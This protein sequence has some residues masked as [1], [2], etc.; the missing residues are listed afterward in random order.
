MEK[1]NELGESKEFINNEE[2]RL[3]WLEKD[4]KEWLVEESIDDSFIDETENSLMNIKNKILLFQGQYK[5]PEVW[6]SISTY[7]DQKLFSWFELSFKK[8]LL[9]ND[10]AFKSFEKYYLEKIYKQGEINAGLILEVDSKIGLVNENLEAITELIKNENRLKNENYLNIYENLYLNLENSKPKGRTKIDIFRNRLL[11]VR[12]SDEN[13]FFEDIY[14]KRKIDIDLFNNW[15]NGFNTIIGGK[16]LSGK[17]RAVYELLK[18]TTIE[19]INYFKAE[20]FPPSN[21]NSFFKIEKEVETILVF[22]NMEKILLWDNNKVEEFLKL[23]FSYTDNFIVGITN[24]ISEWE[25]I[26]YKYD[27]FSILKIPNLTEDVI[28]ELNKIEQINNELLDDTIGSYFYPISSRVSEYKNLSEYSKGVLRAYLEISKWRKNHLGEIMLL[29]QYV[30]DFEFIKDENLFKKAINEISSLKYWV[31]IYEENKYITLTDEV[32]KSITNE[33]LKNY[34][35]DNREFKISDFFKERDEIL[36][37]FQKETAFK[38]LNVY[39][40]PENH[41]KLIRFAKDDLKLE[42]MIRY[43]EQGFQIDSHMYVSML[44]LN[45]ETLFNLIDEKSIPIP[46]DDSHI[47]RAKCRFK[48]YLDSKITIFDFFE[49]KTP[50]LEDRIELLRYLAGKC[51]TINELQFISNFCKKIGSDDLKIGRKIIGIALRAQR[52]GKNL[53]KIDL[54]GVDIDGQFINSINETFLD[55]NSPKEK[56]AFSIFW[57]IIIFS[58]P[59]ENNRLVFNLIVKEILKLKEFELKGVFFTN[60]FKYLNNFETAI[61]FIEIVSDDKINSNNLNKLLD[62]SN[63]KE[64][65]D[66]VNDKYKELSLENDKDLYYYTQMLYKLR[67]FNRR[68]EAFEFYFEHKNTI[69]D[70]YLKSLKPIFRLGFFRAF[71][72]LNPKL[73]DLKLLIDLEYSIRGLIPSDFSTELFKNSKKNKNHD[74]IDL[75]FMLN[76]EFKYK[77][78][79]VN[80]LKN[81]IDNK[82]LLTNLIDLHPYIDLSNP[83]IL[84]FI[85]FQIKSYLIKK[86][87][88][89]EADFDNIIF[90]NNT[91]FKGTEVYISN[92]EQFLSVIRFHPDKY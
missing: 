20:A 47:I 29:W 53:Q 7:F 45:E 3:E 92:L 15:K 46:S 58:L 41:N 10:N 28:G 56:E 26:C 37:I 50:L 59:D 71:L 13:N 8:T 36:K 77:I 6:E 22:D 27:Q 63:K 30:Y 48:N 1:L 69:F 85:K 60:V 49:K 90:L 51:E 25:N 55:S 76:R 61:N 23:F 64:D 82:E 67:V 34:I 14:I 52:K 68:N 12:A 80:R 83:E 24:K 81:F 9:N 62:L 72:D 44:N 31:D 78:K 75:I 86:N 43:L 65:L 74:I 2:I 39:N 91:Y 40:T 4:L 54:E 42:L 57:S 73:H 19:E 88:L 17:S 66:K 16:T 79:S 21:L 35:S 89:S 70:L 32:F 84:E 33:I 87:I 5:N 11:G 18:K 38:I